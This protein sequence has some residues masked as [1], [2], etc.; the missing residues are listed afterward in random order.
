MNTL[1]AA[2][3]YTF[4]AQDA[5]LAC[6]FAG[7]LTSTG[8]SSISSKSAGKS[9]S[10]R[11]EGS[12]HASV[13]ALSFPKSETTSTA[14]QLVWVGLELVLRERDDRRDVLCWRRRIRLA[15]SLCR[16]QSSSALT[17]VRNRSIP[18]QLDHLHLPLHSTLI[19][20]EIK[21]QFALQLAVPFVARLEVGEHRLALRRRFA[22][23]CCCG[24]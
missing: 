9:N 4:H 5:A 8:R 18:C 15:S 21:V 2:D 1:R 19:I 24:E 16:S 20:V 12:D 13:Y 14:Y 22:A 10:P 7:F 23:S 3:L 11:W 17:S 6:F